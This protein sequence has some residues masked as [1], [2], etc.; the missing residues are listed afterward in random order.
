MLVTVYSAACQIPFL[1]CFCTMTSA[2]QKLKDS[3]GIPRESDLEGQ[4]DLIT[5]LPQHWGNRDS[6]L[7]G[8][9]QN[10]AC[11]KTQRKGAVTPQETEPDSVGG[12]PVEVW[13]SRGSPQ[14]WGH[15][16]QQSRKFPLGINPLGGHH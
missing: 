14:G 11:A 7:G 4:Q 3:L 5:R 16:Q 10:L 15:W 8:H 13:V 6:S 1:V 12:S 9:K 2:H